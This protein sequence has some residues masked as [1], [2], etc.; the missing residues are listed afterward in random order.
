MRVVCS[1]CCRKG[2]SGT[3]VEGAIDEAK[4]Y[5]ERDCYKEAKRAYQ[6]ALNI[7]ELHGGCECCKEA[8]K[9]EIDRC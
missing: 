4:M 1:S 5:Y 8:L 6:K 2:W 9:R 3:T 7:L